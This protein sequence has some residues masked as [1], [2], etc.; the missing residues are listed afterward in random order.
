M[1]RGIF[2]T[3][4]FLFATLIIV[5]WMGA[6]VTSAQAAVTDP[7]LVTLIQNVSTADGHRYGVVDD[8]NVGMDTLKI[9][10]IKQGSYI[11]VYHHAINSV[12]QVRLATS[13]NLLTWHYV[14]TLQTAASQPTIASLSDGGFLVAFEKD[15]EGKYCGGFG[16]CLAFKHYASLNALLVGSY[17]KSIILKRTL[18]LCQEG[19]PNIYAATLNPDI[20]HSTISVGFHYQSACYVDREAIGTLTNFSTWRTQADTNVNTLFSKLGTIKGNIGDRD[21]FLY[22]GHSY[23]LIEAQSTRND[24]NTWR[25]YL[26]DRTLN[27]L[28]LL[29]LHT[30]GGSTAFGNPTYTELKLPNGQ[31][32]FVSTEFIFSQGAAP[33]EGGALVYYK[34]YPT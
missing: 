34:A 18:S 6:L 8:Q 19:T 4:R 3:A 27:S 26:F 28:T 15:S 7:G 17:D 22:N 13:A 20:A 33:G 21:A 31:L 2:A 12:F 5:G 24:Y 1:G 32:G 16:G 30:N 10:A 11:A 29:T 9:I 25:P 14:T 23:S